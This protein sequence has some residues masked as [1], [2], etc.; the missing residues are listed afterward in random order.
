MKAIHL[1]TTSILS[2]GVCLAAL[3][4]ALDFSAT[5]PTA[6]ESGPFR[7]VSS[8]PVFRNSSV[9]EETVAEIITASAD[10]QLLVYTDGVSGRIGFV[11]IADPL[12]PAPQGVIEVGG[13]PT[14]VAVAGG[15]AL[16][17]VNTSPDYADPSGELVVIDL[18]S[19]AI[20]RRVDLGGQPDSIAVSPDARFAAIAVENERD[21]EVNEG[22]LPQ[23][24]PGWLTIVDL[25]GPVDG[26][27]LRRVD[28]T[29]ICE[30]YPDDPEPEFV[31]INAENEVVLSLQENNHLV[32]V[33][34]EDGE[35]LEHFSAGSVD[36]VQVD[37]LENDLIEL[38]SQLVQVPREPDSVA[39]TSDRT[40]FT[41]DEGDLHGGGRGFTCF[42]E[43]GFPIYQSGRAV[44]HLT[45]RLG[46]Y[47]EKRSENKGAEPEGLE[48][49]D[50]GARGRFLFVGCERASLVLVYQLPG[51]DW[52]GSASPRLVQ[53]L[54]TGL[55]PEGLVAIPQRGLFVSASE[56]DDRGRGY[57]ST[58]TIYALDGP[59]NY[60][61]LVSD[62]RRD[63]T[64][65]PW[66]A[67]SGLA[68]GAGDELFAVHDGAYRE[69][70][71]FT[72]RT[73][74]FP[75]HITGEIVLHD[76]EGVLRRT[77]ESLREALPDG[78]EFDPR[79]FVDA[80]ATVNLDLE[81]VAKVDDGFWLVSEGQGE[82]I[83]GVS[84]EEHRPFAAPNLLLKVGAAGTIRR[85]IPLREELIENQA[86]DGFEGVAVDGKHVYVAFQR[87]WSAAGDPDGKTR[88]G[89]YPLEGSGSWQF[90]YYPLDAPASPNGGGVG[91]SELV[92]LGAGRFAVLERDDQA[93]TDA[94]VKRIYGFDA[95]ALE[96]RTDARLDQLAV[97]EKQL[98]RDLMH[99]FDATGG[100]VPEK[101]EG[102]C[103]RAD[104]RYWIVNDNDGVD[105]NSGETQLLDLGVLPRD[106]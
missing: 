27:K 103:V 45:V 81:G 96:W 76:D 26:W 105:H 67:L 65:I 35:I 58:V 49:G 34:L 3:L 66:G 33:R 61:T 23:A 5:P 106:E 80:D 18:A 39:W 13:E 60:P 59:A 91:V 104:G 48:Y 85:V 17:V 82:L 86:A 1:R 52:A 21:E 2:V 7:R 32:V 43:R 87:G 25:V 40:F 69:S 20:A 54:P 94:A 75:A 10:G 62:A 12:R 100:T 24:P 4:N 57:R 31:D 84:D 79:R 19:R 97:I 101:L 89:R 70:R 14:S 29:G 16:A 38:D 88:V 9:E 68:A 6:D 55:A 64:P 15:F 47:P 77:L 90:V 78:G 98:V 37:T 74:R 99:D 53:T 56:E 36:L 11:D 92:S 83:G 73:D 42:H 28:L 50:F 102:L 8:F 63:G 44:E 41:A 22:E 71:I 72:L 51:D 30:L 46:H 95:S 93:G